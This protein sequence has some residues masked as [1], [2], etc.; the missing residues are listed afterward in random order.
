M[1]IKLL[2][3][4]GG[5]LAGLAII[6]S[7]I[8]SVLMGFSVYNTFVRIATGI[9]S[10]VF[11]GIFA[12]LAWRADEKSP[13]FSYVFVSIFNLV[14]GIMW[15]LL[16][17]TFH[18][19]S[20]YL[21]RF[22]VYYIF[23]VAFTCALACFW[24]YLTKLVFGAHLVANN[25][26]EKQEVLLYIVQCIFFSCLIGLVFCFNLDRPTAKEC[27]MTGLVYTIGV[28][29]ING[30]IAFW[31]GFFIARKGVSNTPASMVT[32]ISGDSGYDSVA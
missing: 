2:L 12:F 29:F 17:T 20:S 31:F 27:G 26:D 14:A 9:V 21:N 30:L 28:W 4:I 7:L 13:K 6:T 24:P 19:N 3:K 10:L 5:T 25:F 11:A 16:S 23:L 18:Y 32:P 22:V 1:D 15:M 8:P